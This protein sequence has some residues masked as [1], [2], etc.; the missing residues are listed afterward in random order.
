MR[1]ALSV[2]PVKFTCFI[3]QDSESSLE[4]ISA[5]FGRLFPKQDQFKAGCAISVLLEDR[6]LTNTQVGMVE[7]ACIVSGCVG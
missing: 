4:S 7:L 3:S 1:C 5:A 6:L 2:R